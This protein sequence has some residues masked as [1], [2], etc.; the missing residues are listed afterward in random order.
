MEA[1]LAVKLILIEGIPG[2]GK[3][4][5]ARKIAEWHSN[6]SMA[7]NLYIEG[8][9]HP[10]DLGWNACVPIEKYAGILQRYKPLQAEIRNNTVFEGD[11]AI[12]AYTLIKTDNR[13]FYTELESYEVYDGRVPDG[14]FFKLHYRR[15]KSFAEE[16]KRK[17][18][19]NIF[20]CA[21]LQNHVNELLFWRNADEGV[22]IEHHNRLIDSVKCLSPALIYLSQPNTR[23][24]IER[25]ARERISP[26]TGDWIDHCISYCENSPFG[27]RHNTKGF[28]GAIEFFVIRKQIELKILSQLSIPHVIIENPDYDWDYVWARIK[29]YLLELEGR[30][31]SS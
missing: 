22:I 15:W 20:E 28:D 3:S 8:Q 13:N 6:R 25:I 2:S 14:L 16:A 18:E 23:E 7:V 19:L 4:T 12:V 27:K 31:F 26:K 30:V 10:A 9:S 21:F 1:K 11:I 29:A 5:F 17:D 24:T